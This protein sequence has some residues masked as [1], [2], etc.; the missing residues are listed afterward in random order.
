[1]ALREQTAVTFRILS[2]TLSAADIAARTGLTADE[3]WKLGDARGRF[4]NVEKKHGFVMESK[5]IFSASL[6]DHIKAMLKRLAPA[7]QKIGALVNECSIEFVCTVHR[8]QA[9]MLRFE[10][11][12]L[13]WLGV[14]GARLD[15]DIFVL[16][17]P[18]ARAPA[19]APAAGTPPP[20]TTPPPSTGG[21]QG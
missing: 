3:T 4:G 9:P 14:M 21:Y 2:A 17:D 18:G 10:R 16:N 13:R 11:D 12:D 15:V 20:G 1:M 7:A 6:D 19:A 5:A 8:K